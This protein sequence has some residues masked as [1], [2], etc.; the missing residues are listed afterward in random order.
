MVGPPTVWIAEPKPHMRSPPPMMQTKARIP[1]VIHTQRYD[2]L[3]KL[4]FS[5][6]CNVRTSQEDHSALNHSHESVTISCSRFSCRRQKETVV[7]KHAARQLSKQ[8][9]G[10]RGVMIPGVGHAWNL[11]VPDLF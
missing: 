1:R 4:V 10:A 2:F 6:K 5:M 11:E 8:I 7:A 9:E 3:D